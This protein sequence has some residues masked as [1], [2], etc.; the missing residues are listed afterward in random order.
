MNSSHSKLVIF[1]ISPL[2]YGKDYTE[3]KDWYRMNGA[4]N[5]IV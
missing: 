2:T 5:I 3:T 1:F 4:A